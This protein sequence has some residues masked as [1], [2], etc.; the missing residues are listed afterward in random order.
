MASVDMGGNLIANMRANV[1]AE[2]IDRTLACRLLELTD[3]PG[4]KDLLKFLIARD[5]MHQQQW[6]AV[7]EELG[8]PAA[9]PIPNSFPQAQENSEFSYTYVA[10]GVDGQQPPEGRWSQGPSIDGRGE[11]SLRH[12][13]PLGEEPL[14]SSPAADTYAQTQQI[15]G[16]PGKSPQTGNSERPE[17]MGGGMMD[18][19]KERIGGE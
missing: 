3:D 11:F 16:G 1:A 15:E 7:L 10:T 18:K 4:M 2:A 19:I 6:L 9:L 14:L 13:Q 17:Q 5:T 8:G 12:A